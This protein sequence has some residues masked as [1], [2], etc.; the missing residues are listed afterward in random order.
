MELN[1]SRLALARRRRGLSKTTLA[2]RTGISVRSLGY[3]E[4]AV[5][6]VTPSDEHKALLAKALELPIE[7]F[8]GSDIEEITS[9]AA[10]FRSLKT[11]TA[12]LRESAIGAGTFA[13]MV[14]EWI[15]KH[16]NLPSPSIPSLRDFEPEAAAQVLRTEW[17]LGERPIHNMVHLAESHGVRV[18][19]LPIDS[20]KVD[21]FSVLHRGTTPYVFLNTKKSAE[22][23]RFDVAHELGHLTLHTHTHGGPSGSRD[24]ELEAN[25]FASAFLMPRGDVLGHIPPPSTITV[26]AIHRLKKRWGVSAIALVFRLHKLKILTEWQ[27][28]TLCIQLSAAGFKSGEPDGMPRETSQVFAKVFKSLREDGLTRGKIARDLSLTPSEVDA[29]LTG[30]VI[31]SVPNSQGEGANN[32]TSTPVRD[33][34]HL[35]AV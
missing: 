30:L 24:A 4:S 19:S 23:S 9:E 5:S 12:S 13:K 29:L 35:R 15:E 7:F 25:R 33:K 8:S 32:Q 21:A 26:K 27:Y 2:E 20:L 31:A 14:S 1:P 6:D 34:S 10:S 28:R 22:H 11:L 17:G 16:F 3:Y 18:F